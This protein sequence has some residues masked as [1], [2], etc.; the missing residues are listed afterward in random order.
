MLNGMPWVLGKLLE[1]DNRVLQVMEV[2]VGRISIFWWFKI[3]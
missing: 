2:E 1:G 3:F